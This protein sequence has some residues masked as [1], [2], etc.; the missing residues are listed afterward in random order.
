[1]S[2]SPDVKRWKTGGT[3]RPEKKRRKAKTTAE[4]IKALGWELRIYEPPEPTDDRTWAEVCFGD[5]HQKGQNDT[6]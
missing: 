1:M 5:D 4:K 3:Y 6:L 2:K